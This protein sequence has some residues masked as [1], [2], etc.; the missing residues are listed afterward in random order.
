MKGRIALRYEPVACVLTLALCRMICVPLRTVLPC[1]WRTGILGY[2]NFSWATEWQG[3]KWVCGLGRLGAD[4]RAHPKS[5]RFAGPGARCLRV[6]NPVVPA[7]PG[8]GIQS[9][10]PPFRR[11][12]GLVRLSGLWISSTVPALVPP[13]VPPVVPRN[14]LKLFNSLVAVQ[15]ERGQVAANVC[16]RTRFEQPNLAVP[17]VPFYLNTGIKSMSYTVQSTEQ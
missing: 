11:F 2:G 6:R 10:R 15:T 9:P 7:R 16:A 17:S 1:W 4:V 8:E 3:G 13:F 12:P 14:A 5:E